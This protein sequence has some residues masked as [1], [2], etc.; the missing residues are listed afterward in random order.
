IVADQRERLRAVGQMRPRERRRD[1]FALAGM[2]AGNGA[3]L[4][5]RRALELER[6]QCESHLLHL[7]EVPDSSAENDVRTSAD[8]L[9]LGGAPARFNR[10]F[11]ENL[12]LFRAPP[13]RWREGGQRRMA[14]SETAKHWIDGEWR[15]SAS[16]A[17]A[18]SVNPGTGE[19]LGEF[20]DAGPK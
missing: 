11:P 15:S 20:A 9:E 2:L 16:G 1:V 12:M 19:T 8:G 17:T 5:E 18:S 6:R 10:G 13:R 3:V 14:V 7:R 4:Q